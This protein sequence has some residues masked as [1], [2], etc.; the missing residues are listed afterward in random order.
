MVG[1]SLLVC[2]PHWHYLESDVDLRAA[3]ERP[4]SLAPRGSFTISSLQG[5][6]GGPPGSVPRSLG[7]RSFMMSSLHGRSGGGFGRK[8]APRARR[9][10][11][12]DRLEAAARRPAS[13][14]DSE[15]PLLRSCSTSGEPIVDP[16]RVP[17]GVVHQAIP[18]HDCPHAESSPP[19]C[20]APIEHPRGASVTCCPGAT[21]M[22]CCRLLECEPSF[23]RIRPGR[24]HPKHIRTLRIPA[25]FGRHL[26]NSVKRSVAIGPNWAQFCS[27]PRQLWPDLAACGLTSA[28]SAVPTN[29]FRQARSSKSQIGGQ[30]WPEFDDRLRWPSAQI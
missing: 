18:S 9:R 27:T 5:R 29:M 6:S 4:R 28:P 3:R 19:A 21:S 25:K 2:P 10:P 26:S 22:A 12:S 16:L 13:A 8:Q 11:I 24:D 30:I 7:R 1:R 14:R 23:D 20:I 17:R 15:Q